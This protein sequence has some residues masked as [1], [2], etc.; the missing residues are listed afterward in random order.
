MRVAKA[1]KPTEVLITVDTEFTIGG[2][3]Y[4]PELLPVA[5]PIVLGEVDGKEH[6]LGFL[7]IALQSLGS[8]PLSLSRR[9]KQPISATSR[10]E[11]SRGE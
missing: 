5:E 9:C 7:L 10:W 11:K 6:G 2:N 8:G 1:P 3:F 4:D